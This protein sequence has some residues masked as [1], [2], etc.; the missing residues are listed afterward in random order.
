VKLKIPGKD[1]TFLNVILD[2][3]MAIITEGK[4]QQEKLTN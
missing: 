3:V 1:E 4:F 2:N